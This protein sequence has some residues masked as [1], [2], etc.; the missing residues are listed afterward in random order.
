MVLTDHS[1]EERDRICEVLVEIV[2]GPSV[3]G[4][5]ESHPCQSFRW[6]SCKSRVSVIRYA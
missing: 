4:G 3:P 2:D 6:L 5:V 1:Q